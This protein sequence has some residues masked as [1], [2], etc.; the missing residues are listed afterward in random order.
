MLS[1]DLTPIALQTLETLVTSNV[2]C[3]PN[4][5]YKMFLQHDV[6]DSKGGLNSSF[7][8][9]GQQIPA[10]NDLPLLTG[11]DYAW[12]ARPFNE[13]RIKGFTDWISDVQRCSTFLA[14]YIVCQLNI[15]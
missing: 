1:I 6:H 15:T 11:N 4:Y 2:I 5:I 10:L 14:V 12:Y 13:V 8:F 9:P 7:F 3:I